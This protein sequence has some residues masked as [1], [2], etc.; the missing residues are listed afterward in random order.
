MKLRLPLIWVDTVKSMFE[1][2]LIPYHK[3]GVAVEITVRQTFALG[4]VT[5]GGKDNDVVLV[6]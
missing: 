6:L 1:E 4:N 5:L 3:V 2:L